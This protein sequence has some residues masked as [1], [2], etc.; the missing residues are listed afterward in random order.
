MENV[1]AESKSES[2]S[3]TTR[4]CAISS[5]PRCSNI[6]WYLKPPIYMC[7]A[8]YRHCPTCLHPSNEHLVNRNTHRTPLRSFPNDVTP[9][10][11]GYL[12]SRHRHRH[13]ENQMLRGSRSAPLLRSH[14]PSELSVYK[15]IVILR[16]FPGTYQPP[17]TPAH[18]YNRKLRNQP[19]PMSDKTDS[20]KSGQE[21]QFGILP[22]PA[23]RCRP[24]LIVRSSQ[25]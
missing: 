13:D 24:I 14:C 21:Q 18:P 6:Q 10:L 16:R 3:C 7:I 9:S 25:T 23:V 1:P 15:A 4:Y 8:V 5:F 22:H 20:K 17:S 11:R 19:Q 2:K 12:R